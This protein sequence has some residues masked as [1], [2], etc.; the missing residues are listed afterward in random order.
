M[1]ELLAGR[2]DVAGRR[3]A[4]ADVGEGLEHGDDGAVP[5]RSEQLLL[6]DVL[7]RGVV[8]LELAQR[9]ADGRPLL[10]LAQDSPDG[11]GQRECETGGGDEKHLKPRS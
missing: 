9:G 6:T 3:E 2:L 1:Y 11:E 10:S 5:Q 8:A 4:A 7:H